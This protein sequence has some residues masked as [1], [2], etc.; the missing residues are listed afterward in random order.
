MYYFVFH[1]IRPA[2]LFYPL[3]PLQ[4]KIFEHISDPLS[5]VSEKVYSN[6]HDMLP[7]GT[8]V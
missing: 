7:Q 2:D 6:V 5:D 8:R 4:F 1:T 3:Q